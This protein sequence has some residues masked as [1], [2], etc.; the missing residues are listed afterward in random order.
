MNILKRIGLLIFIVMTV[1]VGAV[2]I[3]GFLGKFAWLFELTSHFRVQYFVILCLCLPAFLAAKS[4]KWT[5][6]VLVLMSVNFIMF[7]P[8]AFPV[9]PAHA[10]QH[11]KGRITILQSNVFT[12]NRSHS[13]VARLIKRANPDVIALM[14]IN[15]RW[16]QA[17]EET[18][19]D[20][21]YREVAIRED[22][23]GIGLF[24]RI[25][26]QKAKIEYFGEAEVPTVIA[27]ILVGGEQTTLLF[28]HPLPPADPIYFSHRNRQ[29]DDIS[30]ARDRFN[31]RLIVVGD[32]NSSPWSYYFRRF[33]NRMKLQDTRKGFGL[34]PTWP[35]MLRVMMIPL[36]HCLVSKEF[37][38]LNRK[39]GPNVGSDHLPVIVELGLKS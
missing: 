13:K 2:T 14:E 35:T 12:A 18:L 28:T 8:I 34:H 7:N 39:V 23:F 24:S 36:D 19:K 3:T 4:K 29:L 31:D 6:V 38:T 9:R 1:G 26:F 20:Y 11:L 17:L 32:L 5:A 22:N 33:I 15:E 10:T 21:P 25:P 37:V 30:K 16:N 27:D